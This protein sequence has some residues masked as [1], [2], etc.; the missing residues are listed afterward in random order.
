MQNTCEISGTATL[1]GNWSQEAIDCFNEAASLWGG[2]TDGYGFEVLCIDSFESA[3]ASASISGQPNGSPSCCVDGAWDDWFYAHCKDEAP[4][5]HARLAKLMAQNGLS[6]F[7][8]FLAEDEYDEEC[9]GAV[10]TL[11]L[12]SDGKDL[13]IIGARDHL[14]EL[15]LRRQETG[16]YEI[17]EGYSRNWADDEDYDSEDEDYDDEDYDGE[18]EDY[19][20]EEY[21]GEEDEDDEEVDN[22]WSEEDVKDWDKGR[23]GDWLYEELRDGG[24]NPQ[25]VSIARY[26]GPGGAVTVPTELDGQKVIS[27]AGDSS[28]ERTRPGGGWSC[29]M[30]TG[31]FKGR[32]DVTS[33]MLPEGVTEIGGYAFHGCTGL[34]SILLPAGLEYIG[35]WAFD[36]CTALEAVKL[37]DSVKEI[38]MGAF[39]KCDSMTALELGKGLKVIQSGAFSDCTSLTALKLP[40]NLRTIDSWAFQN[41]TGLTAIKIPGHVTNLGVGAF[42]DCTGLASVELSKG[43]KEFPRAFEGC[44][45]LESV[46][47]PPKAKAFEN[48]FAR[49]GLK[50]VVVSKGVETISEAAFAFCGQLKHVDLPDSLKSLEEGAFARCISLELP[51]LPQSLE[52]V[53]DSAFL[54]CTAMFEQLLGGSLEG[55]DYDVSAS[56]D[57]ASG[58]WRAWSITGYHGADTKIIVPTE[59]AGHAIERIAPEA[60]SAQVNESCKNLKKVTISEGIGILYPLT[61]L[62]CAELEE[63]ILPESLTDMG[64]E[65]FKGCKKLKHLTIPTGTV[66]FDLTSVPNESDFILYAKAGSVAYNFAKANWKKLVLT[67]IQ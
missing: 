17:Y 55:Y 61:F 57:T 26:V 6:V 48:S 37:P 40:G 53:A 22:P 23:S 4:E 13:S 42:S 46:T 41:C 32:T 24:E 34:I 15:M 30:L 36:G 25:G 7:L 3:Q 27:I 21:N 65:P 56:Y 1:I 52:S 63:V 50:S 64:E 18:D 20:D 51:Q 54:G 38:G 59:V 60:F 16:E 44:T 8:Y 35:D 12:V 31:A 10:N 67:E 14:R 39:Q 9:T 43:L 49:S 33:V 62:D 47:I 45:S 28:I 19:D 5:L 66:Y 2:I 29:R 11:L 58:V